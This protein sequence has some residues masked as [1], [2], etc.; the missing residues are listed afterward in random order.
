LD[1]DLPKWQPPTPPAGHPIE[2]STA[3]LPVDLLA[4]SLL[5]V[6]V[7]SVV[8]LAAEALCLLVLW[9]LPPGRR[10]WADAARKT[11]VS[12]LVSI[13]VWQWGWV[14]PIERSVVLVL[15]SVGPTIRRLW[16]WLN[17]R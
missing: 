9:A 5:A 6:A 17:R 10:V 7:V 3:P 8:M 12:V 16:E 4:W 2:P 11:A 13:D 15:R 14:V 1:L